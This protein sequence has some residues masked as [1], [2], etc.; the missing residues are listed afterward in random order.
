MN[1]PGQNTGKRGFMPKR[2]K[3]QNE[4]VANEMPENIGDLKPIVD[5]FVSRMKNLENE[6]QLLKESKKEL[7]EE[8]STKLDTKTLK[9]ALRVVDVK[10]K[11][12]HKHYFDLFLRVLEGDVDEQS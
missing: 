12:Q 8:Y 11:V 5:E 4:D 2:S 10:S 7:I 9:M 3:K 6:E 1:I